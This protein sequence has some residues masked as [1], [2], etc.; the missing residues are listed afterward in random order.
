MPPQDFKGM[1]IDPI[2]SSCSCADLKYEKEES[3]KRKSIKKNNNI[4]IS[5]REN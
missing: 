4:E 3:M 1:C 2:W 5:R